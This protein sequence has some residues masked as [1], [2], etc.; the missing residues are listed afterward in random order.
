MTSFV[1]LV[2]TNFREF[3]RDRQALFWTIAFP[4]VFVGIFGIVLGGGDDG[5]SYDIGLVIE[6]DSQEATVLA[7]IM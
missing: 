7:A 6:D 3:V 1:Q 2:L 5:A 4:I